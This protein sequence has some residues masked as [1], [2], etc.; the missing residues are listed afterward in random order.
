M[1]IYAF[2][3]G[4]GPSGATILRLSGKDILKICK[5]ITKGKEH[6][7]ILKFKSLIF[8]MPTNLLC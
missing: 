4:R 5:E 3:S 2:L 1:N 7:D 8:I 6:V